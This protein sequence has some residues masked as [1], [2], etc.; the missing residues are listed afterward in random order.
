MDEVL[1]Q[2]E[3]KQGKSRGE[4]PTAYALTLARK[5]EP[6]KACR[7]LMGWVSEFGTDKGVEDALKLIRSPLANYEI[8]PGA[9]YFDGLQK[10]RTGDTSLQSHILQGDR[11]LARPLTLRETMIARLEKYFGGGGNNL[12]LF[13]IYNDTCTATVHTVED[14]SHVTIIPESRNLITLQQNVDFIQANQAE[15]AKET[16]VVYVINRDKKGQKYNQPLSETEVNKNE[17]WIFSAE[18]DTK[19]IEDYADLAYGLMAQRKRT[20]RKDTTGMGF[21]LRLKNKITKNQ[22][23]ARYIDELGDGSGASGNYDIYILVQFARVAQSSLA[24]GEPE[25]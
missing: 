15:L 14:Q 6:Y 11:R 23:R 13:N 5:G 22:L 7:L 9:N 12:Q 4:N 16:G 10:L 2:L 18:E 19:T 1:R 17:G 21:Y 3:R 24:E 25:N 20:E 8:V